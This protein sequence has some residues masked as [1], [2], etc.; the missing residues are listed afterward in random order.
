MVDVARKIGRRVERRGQGRLLKKLN[1]KI[2][3]F[4]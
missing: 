3:N 1:R 4:R 2:L